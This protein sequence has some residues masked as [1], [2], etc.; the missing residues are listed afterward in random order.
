MIVGFE[1]AAAGLGENDLREGADGI[2]EVH[3]GEQLA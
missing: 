1:A 2:V 3:I